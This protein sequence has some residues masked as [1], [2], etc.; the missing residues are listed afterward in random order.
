MNAPSVYVAES[1]PDTLYRTSISG[2]AA[3][4]NFVKRKSYWLRVKQPD[5][6]ASR[7]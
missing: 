7:L 3:Q 4:P 6:L 2:L 5:V 1:L